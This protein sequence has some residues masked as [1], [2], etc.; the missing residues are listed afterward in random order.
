MPALPLLVFLHETARAHQLTSDEF[1][2]VLSAVR[3]RSAKV[4]ARPIKLADGGGLT[5]YIPPSGAKSWRYRYRLS[6]KEQTLTIGTYPEVSLEHA[7]IAHRA[8]R[9]LVARGL[10][11]LALAQEDGRRLAGEQ[12]AAEESSFRSVAQR[13]MDATASNLSPRTVRH[14]VAM[15]EKHVMPTIGAC[16]IAEVSRKSL[17]ELLSALDQVS[18]VTARHCRGYIRQIFE[19]A[20]DAELIAVNPTPRARILVNA[21]KRSEVPRRSLPIARLGEFLNCL[22][23]APDTSADTKIALRLLI[24]TWCRTSEVTG[25]QWDEFDLD[26][27][28]W[29]IPANRMKGREIHRVYLSVQAAQLLK[30]MG[31][32]VA[33]PVFPN[34]RHPSRTMN[35]MTLTNWRKRWGFA[36]DMDIHGFRALAS[37][38]ANESGRYRPDVIEVALAHKEGDRVRAAYNRAQFSEELKAVWQDWADE[39]DQRERVAR[40]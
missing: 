25:A 8:A 11:P 22:A 20:E 36:D 19:F 15:L 38:W 28:V 35:R 5:L 10:H 26:S 40:K 21:S 16:A 7:R 9:W 1:T 18:P 12:R 14:R 31:P 2:R 6:G 24:L 29:L 32:R 13:W 3:V 17:H 33:G 30:K 27:G 37:T 23:D 34:R 4:A 39:C